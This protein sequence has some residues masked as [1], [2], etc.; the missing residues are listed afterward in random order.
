MK[1]ILFAKIIVIFTFIL[2][3]ESVS[4]FGKKKIKESPTTTFLELIQLDFAENYN[5]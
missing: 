5:I 3:L 2:N 4:A 1:R